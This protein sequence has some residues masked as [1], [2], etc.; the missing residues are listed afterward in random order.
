ARAANGRVGVAMALA[1]GHVTGQVLAM[2]LA[3]V[4]CWRICPAIRFS[5]SRV[6]KAGLKHLLSLGG[7][8]QLLA[9]MAMAITD[10]IK[11]LISAMCGGPDVVGQYDLAEKLLTLAKSFSS[12]LIAPLMPAFAHLHAGQDVARKH[13]LF[14]S[15]SKLVAITAAA[16]LAA[17]VVFADPLLAAW[18]GQ[19][20]PL[21]A[22]T[23]RVMAA[24]YF[25]WLMTGVGTA[26]LRGQGTVRLEL[27]NAVIRTLIA[28]AIIVPLFVSWGGEPLY[29]RWGYEGIILGVLLS[30]VVSSI[31]FLAAFSKEE[32]TGFISYAREILGKTILVGVLGVLGGFLFQ[33]L[34]HDWVPSW[35]VRWQAAFQVLVW[36]SI[37]GL[38]LCIGLW[39]GVL[40][41]MERNFFSSKVFSIWNGWAKL[42]SVTRT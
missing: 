21:A 42:A 36:G 15:S 39:Y 25:F 11:I 4:M 9:V 6:T 26:S 14:I 10:G 33:N 17:T 30:R 24:G 16:A 7:R 3:R 22:W 32:G 20:C 37:F 2:I 27:T 1:I 12:S 35:S 18:A 40:A 34:V 28:A 8:F 13:S 23:I 38:L 41:R 31:W 29:K 5:L 19:E